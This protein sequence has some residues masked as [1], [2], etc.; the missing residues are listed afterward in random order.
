MSEIRPKTKK[1]RNATPNINL[2]VIDSKANKLSESNVYILRKLPEVS[3]REPSSNRLNSLNELEFNAKWIN[4]DQMTNQITNDDNRT[5]QHPNRLNK[6]NK[7]NKSTKKE[8]IKQNSSSSLMRDGHRNKEHTKSRTSASEYARPTTNQKLQIKIKCYL[9]N[10]E[11][12]AKTIIKHETECLDKWKQLSSDEKRIAIEAQ[13][14]WLNTHPNDAQQPNQWTKFKAILQTCG[15]CGRNFFEH[16]LPKH[17]LN[18]KGKQVALT[19]F[20]ENSGEYSVGNFDEQPSDERSSE[21]PSEKS[22]KNAKLDESMDAKLDAIKDR[23]EESIVFLRK[24]KPLNG[25]SSQFYKQQQLSL[26]LVLSNEE[27][28]QSSKERSTVGPQSNE[29][30]K[31]DKTNLLNQSTSKPS[32][33][34]RCS[35]CD[36]VYFKSN[37][38]THM[39][40]HARSNAQSSSE[41]SWRGDKHSDKNFVSINASSPINSIVSSSEPINTTPDDVNATQSSIKSSEADDDRKTQLIVQLSQ[42]FNPINSNQS[43]QTDQSNPISD[44]TAN[45]LDGQLMLNDT[46]WIEHLSKLKKCT[47][48]NRTFFSDRIRKHQNTCKAQPI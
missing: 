46:E 26:P 13:K 5:G 32:F 24:T 27:S 45:Q 20:N 3:L 42:Q 35:Q 40:F 8:F 43:N 36:R 44:R 31:T 4:R 2:P 7:V 41:D 39:Q 38:Q 37:I 25:K 33:F 11:F 22:N 19:K 48:C 29:Q 28:N 30:D 23:V 6:A 9:C 17:E 47:K 14:E 21:R 1:L 10:H 15:K 18:C 16:R 12:N 34:T